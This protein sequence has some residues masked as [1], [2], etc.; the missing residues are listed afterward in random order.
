MKI[1]DSRGI[2]GVIYPLQHKDFDRDGW[3]LDLRASLLAYRIV[4]RMDGVEELGWWKIEEDSVGDIIG[5]QLWP[6]D[7]DKR[8]IPAWRF[9][10]PVVSEKDESEDTGGGNGNGEDVATGPSSLPPT[11]T[12]A[13]GG[14]RFAGRAPFGI[15]LRQGI[16]TRTRSGRR[17]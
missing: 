6:H 12:I 14:R 15:R 13:G 5:G 3:D 8:N 17:V 7:K 11:P 9:A 2:D 10:W 4:G 1:G 16:R